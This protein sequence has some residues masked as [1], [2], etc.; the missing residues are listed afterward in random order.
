ML[1]CA[2][3]EGPA[4]GAPTLVVHNPGGFTFDV[5]LDKALDID[6]ADALGVPLAWSSTSGRVANQNGAR[7]GGGWG[8]TVGGGLLTTCGLADSQSRNAR[9]GHTL[10]IAD[11]ISQVAAEQVT[12][13]VEPGEIR[14]SG[15]AIEGRL[16]GPALR[17]SRTITAS[18]IEARLSIVD[19]V[20]ND[21]FEPAPH[22]FRHRLN[23][24]FPL[25]SPTSRLALGVVPIGAR[26][27]E[28]PGPLASD[29]FLFRVAKQPVAELVW[30]ADSGDGHAELTS[31]EAGLRLR[32]NWS[33]D[34]FPTLVVWRNSSPGVN[35]LGLQPSTSRFASRGEAAEKGELIL[36]QPGEGRT[37]VTELVAE[38]I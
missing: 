25:V 12:W 1:R 37:Y 20:T 38:R 24:G 21:G 17:L 30:H 32:A 35:V 31:P 18:T 15:I 9:D 22:M 26:D 6:W 33:V 4:A 13:Q 29:Q 19:M 28:R 3:T 8:D 23:L 27:G 36:L 2:I 11:G 10:G 5:A 14:I 16:G 34:T 7:A